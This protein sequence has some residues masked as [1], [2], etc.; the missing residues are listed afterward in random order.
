MALA[1]SEGVLL[2]AFNWAESSRTVVFFTREY[3]KLAIVDRGGRSIK[4]KRGRLIPF[5][6]LELTFYKSDREARGYISDAELIR[7]FEFQADGTLGRLAYGSAACELLYLL[8]PEEESQQGLFTYFLSYL[9][10][11]DKADKRGLP[12]LFVT[13]FLRLLSHLGYHPSLS[14]CVACGSDIEEKW[15]SGAEIPFSAQRG[16]MVCQACADDGE[17]YIWVSRETFEALTRL[18]TASLE[19]ASA[20]QLGF[21]QAQS[22][23]D[24]LTAFLTY[25][26]GMKS[27]LKS[28]EFLDKLK[29][30][31][32]APD[33]G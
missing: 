2:K 7:T 27:D 13:F 24:L 29:N 20:T 16:G 21:A 4:S 18:Q 22:M 19:E 14:Y 26:S 32:L 17:R 15:V 12:S 33:K 25:Q 5:A 28:L 9:E 11:I 6:V 1:K 3:G 8:L 23:V 30:S 31:H 10:L